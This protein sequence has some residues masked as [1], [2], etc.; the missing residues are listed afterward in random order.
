MRVELDAEAAR[1]SVLLEEG[2]GHALGRFEALDGGTYYTNCEILHAPL[3]CVLWPACLAT[4][5][6]L[7]RLI[8]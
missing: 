5:P 8:D 7:I 3:E 4:V 6:G 1:E 2:L